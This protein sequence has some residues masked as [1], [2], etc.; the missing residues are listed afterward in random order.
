MKQKLVALLLAVAMC[1]S[2][3]A[4]CGDGSSTDNPGNESEDETEENAGNEVG[5]DTD[6]EDSFTWEQ[7]WP[8]GQ[9]ITIMVEEKNAMDGVSVNDEYIGVKM[10]EEKFNVDLQF[11]PFAGDTETRE[12][13][14][15]LTVSSEDMPDLIFG[16]NRDY[17]GY[18]KLYDDGIAMDLTE[19]IETKM[20]N[21]KKILEEDPDLARDLRTQDG[22]YLFVARQKTTEEMATTGNGMGLLI[23][24]DWLDAVGKEAPTTIE[25]WYD[26]LTAFKTMDPNGNGQQDEIPFDAG[27]WALCYLAVAYETVFPNQFENIEESL[28]IVPGTT[29]VEYGPR[30]QEFKEFLEEMNKWYNEGLLGG[31]VDEEGNPGFSGNA[32]EDAITGNL[33]G[34]FKGNGDAG[35]TT[36]EDSLVTLLQQKNPAASFTALSNPMTDDGTIYC[37]RR[38][39]RGTGQQTIVTTDCD[40]IDAVATVLDYML[41][42]E[43]TTLLTWGEEGVTYEVDENGNKYLTEQG[44]SEY[45]MENGEL[46][47]YFKM[48]GGGDTTIFPTIGCFD[49]GSAQANEYPKYASGVWGNADIT[50]TFPKDIILTAEQNDKVS[51][52]NSE[53]ATY[54]EDMIFKF[55][56]GEEPLSNFDAFVSNLERMGI[57]DIVNTYQ[58]IYDAY[59]GN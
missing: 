24:Q 29:T 54:A 40:C 43:G 49:L 48:Y 25:E 50:L 34:A 18:Q 39:G 46:T 12:A 22:K 11:V 4:G 37:S 6:N 8:D 27:S 41:S 19:I 44:L 52:D 9:V 32:M 45:T 56:T 26:V 16:K 10:I 3:L 15:L 14:Y 47:R 30:T 21:Y 59:M 1:A 33:V 42:E 55:I 38:L 35:D 2:L 31:L 58:E 23:R 7:T 28:F 17:Y 13:Q 57:S 20:P 51:S 36:L 5:G 53:L